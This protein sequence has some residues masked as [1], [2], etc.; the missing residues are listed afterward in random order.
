MPG[1][2]LFDFLPTLVWIIGGL[3][4]VAF[5][6]MIIITVKNAAR[7]RRAG[8]NPLTLQADIATRLLDSDVLKAEPSIDAR[9]AK[10]DQL[11]DA[12]TI[13]ADEHAAAR[14]HLLTQL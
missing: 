1:T 11:R 10:I 9:L 6:V 3:V 12:G 2:T 14:S 5:V 4:A 7:V 8:H 13:S